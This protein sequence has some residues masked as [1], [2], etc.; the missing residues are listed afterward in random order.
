[1]WSKCRDQ[2]SC[3][4]ELGQKRKLVYGL[5]RSVI[6]CLLGSGVLRLDAHCTLSLRYFDRGNIIQNS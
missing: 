5:G 4:L 1:M 3:Y 2:F 6:H